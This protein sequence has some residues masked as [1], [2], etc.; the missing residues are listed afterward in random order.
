[1]NPGGVAG[2]TDAT[3]VVKVNVPSGKEMGMT[4][5]NPFAIEFEMEMPQNMQVFNLS[6][7]L[8]K[9]IMNTNLNEKREEYMGQTT[10]DNGEQAVM[11]GTTSIVAGDPQ[12]P[13]AGLPPLLRVQYFRPN[14][15]WK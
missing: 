14:Y 3:W 10:L 7:N 9:D 11:V 1:M 6:G 8:F 5:S 15:G 13:N 2:K 12:N 4:K